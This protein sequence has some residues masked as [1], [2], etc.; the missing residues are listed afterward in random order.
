MNKKETADR[1]ASLSML[2][3]SDQ[4][5]FEK[6]LLF[7][8]LPKQKGESSCQKESAYPLREDKEGV[9]MPKSALLCL[10]PEAQDGYITLPR[11]W[12]EKL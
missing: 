1:L 2:K 12:E 5:S 9:S 6:T 7:L 3:D 8:A 10:A 4:I 11:A